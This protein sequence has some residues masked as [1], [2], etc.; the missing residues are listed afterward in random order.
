LEAK[1]KK[2]FR[3]QQYETLTGVQQ[4]CHGTSS[5]RQAS[6][7]DADTKAI[8]DIVA[9]SK[10]ATKPPEGLSF[11]VK[12]S[13]PA[14]YEVGAGVGAG[15][16][17]GEGGTAD[18]KDEVRK[19]CEDPLLHMNI[20]E[21]RESGFGGAALPQ[22]SL[23][24]KRTR[25]NHS[26]QRSED[27]PMSAPPPP[28]PPPPLRPVKDEDFMRQLRE[29]RLSREKSERRKAAALQSHMDIYG[30]HSDSLRK[31]P[32]KTKTSH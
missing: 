1:Q 11:G 23:L 25:A 14:W 8:N 29:R 10:E 7:S 31:N 17:G 12:R 26:T 27:L 5:S 16:G 28:P 19:R 22:A 18:A 4:T 2:V 24:R 21:Y 13:R 15:V 9:K 20:R 6:E 30:P 3:E 32:T